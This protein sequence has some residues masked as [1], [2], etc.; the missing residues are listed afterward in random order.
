MIDNEG[1]GWL[2]KPLQRLKVLRANAD[3]LWPLSME[4]YGKMFHQALAQLKLDGLGLTLCAR[5]HAGASYDLLTGRRSY[6]EVKDRGGWKTDSSMQRYAKAARSQQLAGEMP[7]NV[8]KYG[9]LV[10]QDL[11]EIVDGNIEI[12]RDQRAATL[13]QLSKK[14]VAEVESEQVMSLLRLHPVPAFVD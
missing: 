4:A 10:A 5:R 1:F 3:C 8:V 2:A 13:Q 7:Y 12:L 14:A 9:L 6:Q 11:E